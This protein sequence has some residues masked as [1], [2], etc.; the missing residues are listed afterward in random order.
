M[1]LPDLSKRGSLM[2]GPDRASFDDQRKE[3]GR[4][5]WNEEI[6]EKIELLSYMRNGKINGGGDHTDWD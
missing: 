2:H 1:K 5:E 6:C 4:L 3:Q